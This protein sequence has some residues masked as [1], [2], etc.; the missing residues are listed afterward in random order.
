MRLVGEPLSSRGKVELLGLPLCARKSRPKATIRWV[1]NQPTLGS[2]GHLNF[3]TCRMNGVGA[4]YHLLK[5]APIIEGV[6]A[7]EE[8]AT[9]L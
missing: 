2:L 7:M 5:K 6:L 3:P 9:A 1:D 4:S 8:H